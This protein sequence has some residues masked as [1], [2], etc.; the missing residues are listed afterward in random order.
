MIQCS[1]NVEED[2]A[3]AFVLDGQGSYMVQVTL[4][5]GGGIPEAEMEKECCRHRQRQRDGLKDV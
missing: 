2:G 4:S 3:I 1:G 5:F